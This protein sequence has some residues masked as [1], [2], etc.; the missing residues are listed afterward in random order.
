[1]L[2]AAIIGEATGHWPAAARV[3]A[4]S[5]QK[6]DV[7]V[8]AVAC[9][10]EAEAAIGALDALNEKL[11]S[12]AQ[13]ADIAPPA[14][15]SCSGCPFKI[16]CPPFWS[17]LGD[18]NMRPLAENTMAG[19]LRSLEDGPGGDLYTAHVSV[20]AASLALS[21]QQPIALRKSVHGPFDPAAIGHQI[22]AINF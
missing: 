22:R 19:D 7:D 13:P 11:K 18:A 16:I 12:G 9:E 8:N 15:P 20:L 10:A 1:R 3:I 6:L 17:R 2:Y 14:A 21:A 4:A 5:D